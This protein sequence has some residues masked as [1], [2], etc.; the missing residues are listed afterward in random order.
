MKATEAIER[1]KAR[2]RRRRDQRERLRS[3]NFEVDHIRAVE[4]DKLRDIESHLDVIMNMAKCL[5]D[6][7]TED[8]ADDNVT[9]FVL[10]PKA[11]EQRSEDEAYAV[12][13]PVLYKDDM[14]TI[15]V[16]V[17]RVP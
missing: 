4:S 3:M 1:E 12:Q 5:S 10:T 17:T 8:V 16:K 9:N 2:H 13:G 14:V 7:L 11:S 15:E 6:L